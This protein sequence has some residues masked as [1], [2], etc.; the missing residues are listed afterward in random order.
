MYLSNYRAA[1]LAS[2][3]EGASRIIEDETNL[4]YFV[5][6]LSSDNN[7]S[8]RGASAEV[9]GS[10]MGSDKSSASSAAR[11]VVFALS[12]VKYLLS[13]I[14]DPISEEVRQFLVVDAQF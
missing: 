9:L 8:I 12:G 4:M 5:S 6:L 13:M 10:L 14:Q 7:E 2:M 1:S 3:D 11:Q